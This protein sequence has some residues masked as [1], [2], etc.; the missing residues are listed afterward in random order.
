MTINFITQGPSLLSLIVSSVAALGSVS[1]VIMAVTVYRHQVEDKRRQQASRVLTFMRGNYCA[2]VQWAAQNLSD[3]PIYDVWFMSDV[4]PTEQPDK[5]CDGYV[6]VDHI[7]P[8]SEVGRPKASLVT[9]QQG[10]MYV[11]YENTARTKISIIEFTDAAGNR[12]RRRS[13]GD[14]KQL[15]KLASRGPWTWP[16]TV[17]KMIANRSLRVRPQSS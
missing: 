6:A 5:M 10:A 9:E 7:D 2:Q 12:W 14:L 16:A 15:P 11:T 17:K 3:L 4:P 1:A 13:D 8:I